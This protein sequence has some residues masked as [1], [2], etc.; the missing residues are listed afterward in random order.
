MIASIATSSMDS[1]LRRPYL[2]SSYG[3]QNNHSLT[4]SAGRG[5]LE[6]SG[7]RLDL[8]HW[9]QEVVSAGERLV[10]SH[11]A[12]YRSKAVVIVT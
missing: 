8:R 4:T 1:L 7:R 6:G 10:H 11:L 9:S 5:I 2:C 12:L 3:A